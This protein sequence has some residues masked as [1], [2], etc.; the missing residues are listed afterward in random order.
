MAE[1][2][3]EVP[4]APVV[5]APAADPAVTATPDQEV[6]PE[7]TFNQK[8]LDEIVEKRLAKERRKR[9]AT[10]R[11]NEVLRR[12]ALERGERREEPRK[13]AKPSADA[14]PKRENF[15][16]YEAFLE[17]RAEWRAD[18]KVDKRLAE[19]D[20]KSKQEADNAA[21]A[22]QR[23]DFR[24][25]TKELA[26]DLSDFDEVMAEATSSPDSAVSRLFAEPINECEN[27]S[28][29]LYHLAKNPDE[30]ERI[31]DLPGPKQARE[32]WALDAKLK[33]A[34]PPK[35]PSNA[36]EPI[37]PVGG[38]SVKG[39]DMPEVKLADGRVN[40]E[41]TKWRNR[42]EQASKKGN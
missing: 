15:E 5:P 40:P 22:K 28:A 8:E 29:V 42:Q 30:A 12:L 19:R 6:K 11:E 32:I 20:Q 4:A 39:D 27:P 31:A 35:K 21:L 1:A 36:P 2:V 13:E 18:Q 24:K 10:K 3:A 16:T 25:R 14:E 7:R 26:K 38:K 37:N 9:E 41:W 23:E 34:P 33:S 17:A